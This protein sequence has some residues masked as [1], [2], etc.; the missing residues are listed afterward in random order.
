MKE[1]MEE[2][3]EAIEDGLVRRGCKRVGPGLV[4]ILQWDVV[5]VVGYLWLAHRG[6]SPSSQSLPRLSLCSSKGVSS[7]YIGGRA[8]LL[9]PREDSLQDV[10][11]SQCKQ[12]QGP[13]HGE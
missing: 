7:L 9:F 2:T 11:A 12:D 3:L 13:L 5:G 4:N 10:L 1:S 6:V 8:L